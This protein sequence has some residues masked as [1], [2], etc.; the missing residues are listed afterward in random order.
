MDTCLSYLPEEES[1]ED[2]TA[3]W[4]DHFTIIETLGVEGHS[5]DD[6][7]EEHP[8]TYNVRVLPWRNKELVEKLR[9]TDTAKNTTNAYG[10]LR[11]GNRP[12]TRKRRR[13]AKLSQRKP[14]RGKP[15]NYYD[16][17]WYDK[18]TPGQKRALGTLPETPFL[19]TGFDDGY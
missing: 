16:Q 14:P 15:L 13:D 4:Q 19:D 17:E 7:D 1:I 6:T 12:R 2:S 8:N 10:N 9:M 3:A 18:L 11:A 5:S